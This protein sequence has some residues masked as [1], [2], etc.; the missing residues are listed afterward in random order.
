MKKPK[1]KDFEI[2]KELDFTGE[3]SY[4][5]YRKAKREWYRQKKIKPMTTP[6]NL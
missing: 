6:T 2:S 5:A 4:I 3:K 1:L